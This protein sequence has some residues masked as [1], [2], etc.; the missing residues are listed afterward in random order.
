MPTETSLDPREHFA[1]DVVAEHEVHPTHADV[2]LA[3]ATAH[4]LSAYAAMDKL[5][6]NNTMLWS[7]PA[8]ESACR[9]LCGTLVA[10]DEVSEST[11]AG[12]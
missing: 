11:W 3:D 5:S 9:L 4:L 8:F 12:S 1:V 10:I 2:L 6:R 7:S